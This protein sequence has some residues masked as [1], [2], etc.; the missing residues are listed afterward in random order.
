MIN[1]AIW[2]FVFGDRSRVYIL[3]I[4][5]VLWKMLEYQRYTL[6]LYSTTFIDVKRIERD[7][8]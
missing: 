2:R 8:S 7:N 3:E 4:L 5:A 1:R 6:N